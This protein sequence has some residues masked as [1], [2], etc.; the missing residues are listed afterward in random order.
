MHSQSAVILKYFNKMLTIL[1]RVKILTDALASVASVWIHPRLVNT[2]LGLHSS[3]VLLKII[4]LKYYLLP[5]K[6]D[7]YQQA[8][9]QLVLPCEVLRT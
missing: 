9:G 8:I 2:M 3:H 6:G 4:Q 5:Y 1:V 7:C